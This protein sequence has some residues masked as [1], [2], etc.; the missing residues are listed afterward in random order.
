MACTE[1][2]ALCHDLTAHE[3][4]LDEHAAVEGQSRRAGAIFAEA[5]EH[6]D[7]AERD[8]II[9]P[10]GDPVPGLDDGRDVPELDR[11]FKA[12]QH[13]LHIRVRLTVRQGR[14]GEVNRREERGR[15]GPA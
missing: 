2:R 13:G 1:D 14:R 5:R 3:F 11:R 7:V 12:L 8:V 4:L 6:H 15:R 9:N 10:H